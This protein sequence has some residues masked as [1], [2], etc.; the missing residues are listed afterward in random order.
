[1]IKFQQTI[2]S[3][4]RSLLDRR[5]IESIGRFFDFGLS[6]QYIAEFVLI[7]NYNHIFRLIIDTPLLVLLL[8]QSLMV[9]LLS[10]SDWISFTTHQ[11]RTYSGKQ[12]SRP[13]SVR[14][15]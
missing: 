12:A 2:V 4:R 5:Q 7:G 9:I 13:P 8:L 15:Q 11:A 10:S 1:M 6:V 3:L 14:E